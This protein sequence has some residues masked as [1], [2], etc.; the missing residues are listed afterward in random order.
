M[1]RDGALL[2]EGI[3]AS[4]NSERTDSQN[5]SDHVSVLLSATECGDGG[6]TADALLRYTP[7]VI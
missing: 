5:K 2:S 6:T 4:N 7:L 3:A 1:L